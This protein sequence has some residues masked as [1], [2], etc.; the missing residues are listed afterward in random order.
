MSITDDGDILSFLA[1]NWKLNI[2]NKLM[3]AI[4]WVS[5]DKIQLYI[6]GSILTWVY[7]LGFLFYTGFNLIVKTLDNV[8][9]WQIYNILHCVTWRHVVVK[10]LFNILESRGIVI[11]NISKSHISGKLYISQ[12]SLTRVEMINEYNPP[13][14]LVQTVDPYWNI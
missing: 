4:T 10:N 11:L 3:F 2:L 7:S 8:D 6:P 12:F 5:A 13:L 14:Y 9:L 1:V